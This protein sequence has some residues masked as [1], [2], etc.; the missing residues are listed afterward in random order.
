MTNHWIDIRNSDRMMIIGSNAAENHPIS[1]KWV[2][3]AIESGGKLISVDPRFT[4]TSAKAHLY[5]PMRS[6]TDIAF[7]N[8][9]IKYVLDDIE[10]TPANYNVE[11]ITEYTNAAFLIDPGFK[12]PADM[13]GV[14][15]GYDPKMRKYDKSTWQYQLDENGIPKKDKTL[16]DP[17]C[18]FQLLKE[19]VARYTAEK[20]C[21]ITGTPL[22]AYLEVCKT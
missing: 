6:G 18:V 14:F 15:S 9:M 16:Q 5:A 22:E 20:V 10:K 8:G 17:N 2:T 12:L 3:K 11:Y 13:D 19:H 4:R 7:I 1:F 21:S